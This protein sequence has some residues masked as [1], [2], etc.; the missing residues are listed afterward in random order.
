[1][2]DTGL[3]GKVV[4]ILL[5]SHHQADVVELSKAQLVIDSLTLTSRQPEKQVMILFGNHL[6]KK[7][8]RLEQVM[9]MIF[10]GGR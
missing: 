2:L 6:F 9:L 7:I 8:S 3:I 5:W 10:P 4:R 1:M